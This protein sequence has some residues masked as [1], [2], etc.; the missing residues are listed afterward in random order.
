MQSRDAVIQ[1]VEKFLPVGTVF[2]STLFSKFF[3]MLCY[4]HAD[5]NLP[6]Q[7]TITGDL[8][9][10][11]YSYKETNGIFGPSMQKAYSDYMGPLDQVFEIPA[12]FKWL[13]ETE[14]IST[15]NWG[16]DIKEYD[17]AFVGAIKRQDQ[18][19][20][21]RV[22]MKYCIKDPHWPKDWV[23]S[24][25][26]SFWTGTQFEGIEKSAIVLTVSQRQ[27]VASSAP[28]SNNFAANSVESSVVK[29][30]N[31]QGPIAPAPIISK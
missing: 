31:S 30:Q 28:P 17:G 25:K 23:T 27:G 24:E 20:S 10:A 14:S 3:G 19:G 7:I 12:H 9:F 21:W 16:G 8:T 29:Q 5:P 4:H 11:N 6:F 22:T 26:G 15:S 18:D 1:D 13:G 2:N